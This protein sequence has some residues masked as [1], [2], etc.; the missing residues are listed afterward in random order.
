MTNNKDTKVIKYDT[1]EK[2][3]ENKHLMIELYMNFHDVVISTKAKY[4]LDV[5]R[6]K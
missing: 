3:S 4:K 1:Q 5:D 2:N 6:I